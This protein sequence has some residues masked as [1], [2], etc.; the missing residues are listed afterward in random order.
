MAHAGA[1][2]SWHGAWAI[3]GPFYL[4]MLGHGVH[5]PC[6]QSGAI[7]PF[8]GAAGAASA[9]AGFLMM[10]VAFG[11]GSWMGAHMDGTAA[12]LIEGMAFWS[13]TVALVAWILVQRTGP[14]AASR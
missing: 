3:M 12:P 10:V 14:R 9:L 13:V 1:G 4:F 6:G 11:A 2:Q 5:Q 7:G 8:P